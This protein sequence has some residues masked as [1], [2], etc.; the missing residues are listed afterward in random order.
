MRRLTVFNQI[1][2]D[3]FFSGPG[4]DISWGK[5]NAKDPEWHAF[6]QE[7]AVGGGTLLFGR[8]TYEM[9]ASWWPTAQAAK[10]DPVVA[11]RMNNLPKVVFSRTL[12]RAEWNNTTVVKDDPAAA[13]RRMKKES[14]GGLAVLGSG[15]IVS[16]LAGEGLI[17]E[18]QI[19]VNPVVIGTGRTLFEG[20][21]GKLDLKHTRTRAFNNGNVLLCYEAGR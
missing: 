6:V 20:V 14:G 13:V 11:E 16:L 8:K 7:N 2:L 12:G 21:R 10:D 5:K 9:M 1:T 3:G 15:S 17:D 18:Y 4:G 19:V